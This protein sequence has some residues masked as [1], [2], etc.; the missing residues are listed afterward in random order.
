MSTPSRW[1][2]R[3]YVALMA[4]ALAPYTASKLSL[5]PSS[6]SVMRD[7]ADTT[8]RMPPPSTTRP[9]LAESVRCPGRLPACARRHA[10]CTAGWSSPIDGRSGSVAVSAGSAGMRTQPPMRRAP[11]CSLAMRLRSCGLSEAPEAGCDRPVST[12]YAWDA[13]DCPGICWLSRLVSCA[14]AT[15][16]RASANA[17]SSS[18][19]GSSRLRTR[20]PL[21]PGVL[22][23]LALPRLTP[24]CVCLLACRCCRRASSA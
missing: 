4:P 11:L 7:P 21:L 17:C 18:A 2:V 3:K 16:A 14:A 1:P 5:R 8:P 15:A 24:C 20:T 10:S 6:Y 22:L 13:P 12:S 23:P 9:S 19:V